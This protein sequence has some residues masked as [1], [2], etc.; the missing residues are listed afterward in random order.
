ME[1][2]NGMMFTRKNSKFI[3]QSA[4]WQSYQQNHL[5]ANLEDMG[6]GN[7]GFCL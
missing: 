1:N 4:L 6:K 5:A 3:H 7:Y 2:D